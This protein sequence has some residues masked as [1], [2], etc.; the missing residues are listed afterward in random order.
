M[1]Y[2]SLLW[3]DKVNPVSADNEGEF[4]TSLM[5]KERVVPAAILDPPLSD[6]SIVSEEAPRVKMHV[7]LCPLL[8]P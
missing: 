5:N 1:R 4:L 2:P 7:K 3:V 6:I 8:N